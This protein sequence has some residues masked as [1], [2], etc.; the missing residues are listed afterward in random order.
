MSKTLNKSIQSSENEV[1]DPLTEAVC[2]AVALTT[3]GGAML[4]EELP[5]IHQKNATRSA[6]NKHTNPPA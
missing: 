1:T 2:L 3:N 4:W 6:A 5:P